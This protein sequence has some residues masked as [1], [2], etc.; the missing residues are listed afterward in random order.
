MMMMM[1][2][3]CE[4]RRGGGGNGGRR[5]AGEEGHDEGTIFIFRNSI[6]CKPTNKRK[7]LLSPLS[8]VAT[9]PP[10][11]SRSPPPPASSRR[12]QICF[13]Q[14]GTCDWRHCQ[15][16]STQ[17]RSPARRPTPLEWG[18]LLPHSVGVATSLHYSI[19]CRPGLVRVLHSIGANSVEHN[20]NN[21]CETQ[22]HLP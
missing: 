20:N 6:F 16:P 11:P 12:P 18:D 7:G 13:V 3:L 2:M 15:A 14:L 1:M 17:R 8:P 5:G 19:A 9:P 4:G 10:P 21:H 22:F